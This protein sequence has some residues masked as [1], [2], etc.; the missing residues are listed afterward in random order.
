VR[1]CGLPL[2]R[3]ERA[4]RCARGHAFDVAR[5]GYVNLVQPQDRRSVEAGDARQELE[6]RA[7]L[8]ASGFGAALER[9]LARLA[10]G[11]ELPRGAFVLDLGA[12]AGE[13]LT[14]F[15]Q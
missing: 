7:R 15:A 6:A 14:M 9:E 8:H 3:T 4:F 2:A 11:L 1:G 13:R 12:G 5:S 10:V